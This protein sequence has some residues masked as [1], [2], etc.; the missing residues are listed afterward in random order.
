MI[1]AI[2]LLA[3][4]STRLNEDLEKQYIKI[5]NKEL[6]LYPLTT[7]SL[8]DQIDN[9]I[10]VVRKGKIEE[11]Q[12]IIDQYSFS[13]PIYIVEGG[14]SRQESSFKALNFIK[15]NFL[16]K[17]DYVLIHDAA[18]ILVSPSIILN[19][20]EEVKKVGATTTYLDSYD[21]LIEVDS[22]NNLKNYLNRDKIKKVQTPQAFNFDII[23][24]AHIKSR[25][26]SNDDASLVK[27]LGINVSLV[28]G[29]I[30]NFKITTKEDLKL[31]RLL[32]EGKDEF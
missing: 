9:I 18:R 32:I 16:T 4:P 1:S 29:D 22:I 14:F 2:I 19:N 13:K 12:K 15:H 28:K 21:S 11:T 25:K 3:G 5:N 23:Y 31:L 26:L 30:F 24:Q 6:F 8:I 20:I 7:F 27:D 10:L 17:C